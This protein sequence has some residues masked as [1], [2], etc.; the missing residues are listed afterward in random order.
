MNR[1]YD[2]GR[3]FRPLACW[4]D[5]PVTRALPFAMVVRAFGAP[6]HGV[7]LI[8]SCSR[9]SAPQGHPIA[10]QGN[11]LGLIGENAGALKGRPNS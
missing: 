6:I 2:L 1:R 3:P 4:W 10:A 7:K 9:S 11:A 8:E 5:M